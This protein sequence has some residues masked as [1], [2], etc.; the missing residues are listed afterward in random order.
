MDKGFLELTE[1]YMTITDVGREVLIN[2]VP[3]NTFSMHQDD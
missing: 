1:G 2:D 3:V